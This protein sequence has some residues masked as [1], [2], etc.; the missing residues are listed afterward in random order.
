VGW[1]GDIMAEGFV[2]SRRRG[3]ACARHVGGIWGFELGNYKLIE[4]LARP[5]LWELRQT[6]RWSTYESIKGIEETLRSKET[7]VIVNNELMQHGLC[8]TQEN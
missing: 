8:A 2:G 3:Y 7:H 5:E 4:G 1:P 6:C